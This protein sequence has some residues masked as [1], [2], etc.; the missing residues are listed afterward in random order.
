[1]MGRLELFRKIL[2]GG[3]FPLLVVSGAYAVSAQELTATGVQLAPVVLSDV[4]AAVV[5]KQ[6]VMDGDVA[7]AT[8]VVAQLSGNPPLM[9]DRQGVFQPWDMDPAHLADNGFP[10]TDGG[11]NFKIFNQDLSDRNFPIRVSVYYRANGEL[12]FGYFDVLRT[13]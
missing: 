13:N 12:K 3:V 10:Q 4:V 9:R 1:M 6:I 7:Q 11:V 8:Y 2:L 5:E